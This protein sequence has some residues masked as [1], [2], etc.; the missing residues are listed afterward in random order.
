MLKQLQLFEDEPDPT[1]HE[2]RVA[3]TQ[4]EGRVQQLLEA[5]KRITFNIL[6][7]GPSLR[8][9]SPVAEK[10]RQIHRRLKDEKHHCWFSEEFADPPLGVSLKSYELAQARKADIIVILVEAT[11]TGSIGEMHDFCSH[12]ELLPKIL[13][14]YPEDMRHSYSGEGLVKDLDK[15][16]RI[17]QWYMEIDIT[18]CKV[19]TMVLEWVQARR[20]YV[21]SIT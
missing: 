2:A 1:S 17:V 14:F 5:M 21:Y 3:T 10:R 13:L 15:G 16:F 11:A 4:F 12:H 7:W 20:S 19:L 8:S 6:I 9:Q 18:S